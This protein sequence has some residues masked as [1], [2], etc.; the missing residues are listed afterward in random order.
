[1]YLFLF[2]CHYCNFNICKLQ[3]QNTSDPVQSSYSFNTVLTCINTQWVHITEIFSLF[4]SF[5]LFLSLLL[6]TIFLFFGELRMIQLY[7]SKII[8]IYKIKLIIMLVLTG[9]IILKRSTSAKVFLL[10]KIPCKS[11]VKHRAP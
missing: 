10:F 5:F 2:C 4:L 6:L 11:L 9:C 3:T 7:N 1:M 8:Y